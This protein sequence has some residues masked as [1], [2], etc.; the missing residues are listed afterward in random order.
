MGRSDSVFL[1]PRS[2]SQLDKRHHGAAEF[3]Q[4]IEEGDNDA[5]TPELQHGRVYWIIFSIPFFVLFWFLVAAVLPRV[6]WGAAIV[7]TAWA[8]IAIWR[9]TKRRADSERC[10]GKM[11][12]D[13][14]EP[15]ITD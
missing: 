12:E 13:R 8:G 15:T 6:L 4:P 5:P 9:A 7:A 2:R 10:L 11:A 1:R 3:H 14:K